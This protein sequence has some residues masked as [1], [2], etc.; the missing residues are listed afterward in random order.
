[1]QGVAV[2]DPTQKAGIGCQW[3]DRVKLYMEPSLEAIGVHRKKRV[4]ETEQLHNSF[5]LTQILVTYAIDQIKA[6]RSPPTT[7]L[8]IHIDSPFHRYLSMTADEAVV[9]T[10]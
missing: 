2:L 1:M 6:G 7:Y 3:D 9:W 5:V 4:Y 10:R 8:S